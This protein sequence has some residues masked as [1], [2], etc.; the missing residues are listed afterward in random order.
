M[1]KWRGLREL[2]RLR[3]VPR[4]SCTRSAVFSLSRASRPS[5]VTHVTVQ[6]GVLTPKSVCSSGYATITVFFF[7]LQAQRSPNSGGQ[8]PKTQG[9]PQTRART[10]AP[11]TD[12]GSELSGKRQ[13]SNGNDQPQ[14]KRLTLPLTDGHTRR[15]Y[16]WRNPTSMN[17]SQNGI[18]GSATIV[19]RSFR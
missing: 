10:G 3:R 14:P 4:F 1:L 5:P 9:P 15:D 19:L 8:Q 12:A 6:A 13:R 11:P 7:P 16:R 2:P 17:L 18:L